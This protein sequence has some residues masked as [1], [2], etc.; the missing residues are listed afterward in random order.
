[1]LESFLGGFAASSPNPLAPAERD[2]ALEMNIA[3]VG[4]TYVAVA[5]ACFESRDDPT[6][7]PGVGTQRSVGPEPEKEPL[8]N[9][10]ARECTRIRRTWPR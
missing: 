7:E 4:G 1:M 5:L 6:V 8:I 2:R 10:K 9:A 3:G